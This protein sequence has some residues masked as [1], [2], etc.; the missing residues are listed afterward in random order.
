MLVVHFCLKS[1]I[2]AAPVPPLVA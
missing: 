1:K 2:L